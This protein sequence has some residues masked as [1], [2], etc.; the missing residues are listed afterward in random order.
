MS[1]RGPSC[2]GG[3]GAIAPVAPL[4][5]ACLWLNYSPEDGKTVVVAKPHSACG[6]GIPSRIEQ[7]FERSSSTLYADET[8]PKSFGQVPSQA[9]E[10]LY[11]YLLRFYDVSLQNNFAQNCKT[12]GNSGLLTIQLQILT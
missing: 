9:V 4:S 6:S 1:S 7:H 3:P 2:C 8:S 12:L 5:P 11:K 10:E